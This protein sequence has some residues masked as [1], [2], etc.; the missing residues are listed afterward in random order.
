MIAN[1]GNPLNFAQEVK[2]SENIRTKE[3]RNTVN[4]RPE[5]S[6]PQGING[7]GTDAGRG[8]TNLDGVPG[9]VRSGDGRDVL[10]PERG[11]SADSGNVLVKDKNTKTVT[12]KHTRNIF[13]L[14][15]DAP[16]VVVGKDIIN[17]FII[18]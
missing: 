15:K 10:L 7:Q 14:F 17:N 4:N 9:E 8:G 5:A 3:T 11:K 18:I 16:R 2:S 1:D 6:V 13:S 12:L